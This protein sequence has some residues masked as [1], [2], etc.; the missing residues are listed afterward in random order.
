M[1]KLFP[2]LDEQD[3]APTP[4]ALKSRGKNSPWMGYM[5][6]GKVSHT[7]VG[8]RLVYRA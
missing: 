4:E 3:L 6:T 8:G 7:L 2:E 5:M 1:S